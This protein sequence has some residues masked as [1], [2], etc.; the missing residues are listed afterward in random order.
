M[1]LPSVHVNGGA[2]L[3]LCVGVGVRQECLISQW[4]FS[5]YMEDHEKKIKG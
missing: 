3:A 2:E 4:L 1:I 5:I